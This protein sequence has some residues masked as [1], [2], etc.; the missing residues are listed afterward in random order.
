[1]HIL[2][3]TS[4]YPSAA[5]PQTGLFFRDQALALQRSGH[6]VGVIALPRLWEILHD[7][8]QTRLQLPAVTLETSDDTLPVYRM[9]RI[10]FPRIFPRACGWLTSHYGWPTYERYVADHGQPDVIHAHNIFYA[11]YLASVLGRRTGIPTVLTEHSTNFLRGRIFLPGQ[12][13]IA[14]QTLARINYA[15]AVAPALADVLQRYHPQHPVKVVDNVVDTDYFQPAAAPPEQPL[16]IAAVGTLEKRKGFDL[17][18]RAFAQVFK[19]QAAQLTIG[20]EG[21]DRPQLEALTGQLG[22]TGQV[23]MPGR[24]PRDQ[25]RALFQ[26]SHFV[27]SSSHIETF[28]VTLIE[29]MACGKPVIATR[30]GGPDRFVNDDVGMLVP[31]NDVDGLAEALAIMQQS[32]DHYDPQAIRA[33]CVDHFSEQAIADQLTAIYAHLLAGR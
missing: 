8:R 12:H 5:R 28:G 7:A 3:L 10:W 22:I 25:V 27:V 29:A 16:T 13:A 21:R 9:Q 14:R 20:G 26:R 15:A 18:L 31:V 33:Y 17:L 6:R 1:M 11:G 24:L 4:F 32:L 19:G 30:S 23:A 2:L